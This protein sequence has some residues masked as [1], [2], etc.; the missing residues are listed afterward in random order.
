MEQRG[1][2]LR[3]IR[4]TALSH[5]ICRQTEF[6]LTYGRYKKRYG[7]AMNHICGGYMSDGDDE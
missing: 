1:L 5:S 3:L 4:D 2:N 7:L 6:G